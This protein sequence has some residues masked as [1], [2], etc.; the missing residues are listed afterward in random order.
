GLRGTLRHAA[1]AD[2]IDTSGPLEVLRQA[3]GFSITRPS[4]KWAVVPDN[5]L[6]HIILDGLIRSPDLLLVEPR[7]YR[8]LDAPG[9][10]G[11]NVFGLDNFQDR[12]LADSQP[13]P[14]TPR[15]FQA[16]DRP[17][18]LARV[19]S[20]AVRESRSLPSLDGMQRKELIVDVR[21]SG[22]PWTF[23]IRLHRTPR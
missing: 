16:D 12:V 1:L 7:P 17:E 15:G 23:L 9:E 2:R 4:E 18:P 5:K 13:A 19:T 6:D 3:H 21:C 20:V 10:H 22:Q 14:R 11:H 8:L